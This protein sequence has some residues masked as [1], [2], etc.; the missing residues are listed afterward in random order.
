MTTRYKFTLPGLRELDLD[1]MSEA[2]SI[3][4]IE[5]ITPRAGEKAGEMAKACGYLP[6]ALRLAASALR[7][8]AN[9]T[10]TCPPAAP[11]GRRKTL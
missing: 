9:L 8:Q 4:L 1:T 3:T 6:L 7:E 2:E 11:D 10:V 5:K